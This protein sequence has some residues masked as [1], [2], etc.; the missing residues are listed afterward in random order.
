MA[1]ATLIRSERA[2]AGR[3]AERVVDLYLRARFG[4]ENLGE[5]DMR[6]LREALGAAR[7][8]MRGGEG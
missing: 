2:A 5:S 7:R 1:L 4:R 6:E 3:P 8:D